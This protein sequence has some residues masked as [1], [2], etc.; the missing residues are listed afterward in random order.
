MFQDEKSGESVFSFT[1]AKPVQKVFLAGDFNEWSPSAKRMV[2]VKGGA[3]RAR[4]QLPPGRYE[5]K[6]IVDGFWMQD[7]EAPEQALNSCGSVNSVVIVPEL[8]KACC[9]RESQ[10][11]KH[12]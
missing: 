4:L 12:D 5:Y 8:C 3:Y 10:T 11:C 7:A 2:K 9:D 1:P 6:F